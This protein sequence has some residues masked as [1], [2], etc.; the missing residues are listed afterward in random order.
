MNT[1]KNQL[2]GKSLFY[3][4]LIL[5]EDDVSRRVKENKSDWMFDEHLKPF[6]DEFINKESIVIDAGANIGTHTLYLSKIS[7]KVY[8]FEPQRILFYHLCANL[9]LNKC[10]N[11]YAKNQA[12]YD[13]QT[14]L[15][16]NENEPNYFENNNSATIGLTHFKN[17]EKEKIE[18]VTIDSLNLEKL[19]FIKIDAQGSDLQIL[20]GAKNTIK[21]CSPK[22]IFEIEDKNLLSLHNSKIEDYFLFIEEIGYNK[23]HC[24][25]GDWFI[26]PK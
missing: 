7:K 1:E 8:A 15:Q 25:Y 21:K 3:C 2:R 9:F 19:D 10:L 16:L 18:A 13:K 23:I 14:F 20:K 22:I 4:D 12:L 17:I 6:Y 5:G 26:I 11:V 24:G